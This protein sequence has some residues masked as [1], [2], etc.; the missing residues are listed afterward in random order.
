[1]NNKINI[2]VSMEVYNW[3]VKQKEY[4]RETFDDVL[5]RIQSQLKKP[6]FFYHFRGSQPLRTKVRSMR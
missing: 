3:L 6:Y 4:R 5:R 1:M 2:Q